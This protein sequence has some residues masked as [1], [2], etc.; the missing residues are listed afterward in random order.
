MTNIVFGG[1]VNW[2]VNQENVTTNS[3]NS[4]SCESITQSTCKHTFAAVRCLNN[5]FQ[6]ENANIE[7]LLADANR[8]LLD[9]NEFNSIYVLLYDDSNTVVSDFSY[10]AVTGDFILDIKQQTIGDTIINRGKINLV[11]T[12]EMTSNMLSGNLYAEIKIT[13][14]TDTYIIACLLVAK[15]KSSRINQFQIEL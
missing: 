10:P 3:I 1:N 11:L 15:I 13:S 14:N 12:P 2:Y 7:I 8:I 5:I 6:G 9:L 4:P